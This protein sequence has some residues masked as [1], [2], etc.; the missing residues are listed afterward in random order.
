M[1]TWQLAGSLA[2]FA[3]TVGCVAPP[4]PIEMQSRFDPAE[5]A[6]YMRSGTVRVTGQA[7]LR[8]QGG[9]TVTCAG[10][11]AVLFPA[12]AYFRESTDIVARGGMPRLDNN[13]PGPE[14]KSLYRETRCDAQGNFDL[15]PVPAGRYIV[16]SEVRWTIANSRQGGYLKREIDVV[17]G[18]NNR[19]LLSD[20][21]R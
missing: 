21:D 1:K 7:F 8:Q 14:F 9:G 12:T 20:A 10:S 6:A 4:K 13:R 3:L 5:H 16:M 17:E 15:D 19:F 11:R 18:G 2:A